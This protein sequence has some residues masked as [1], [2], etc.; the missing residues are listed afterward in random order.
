MG[1]KKRKSLWEEEQKQKRDKPLQSGLRHPGISIPPHCL[2]SH[3]EGI[4]ALPIQLKVSRRSISIR[5]QNVAFMSVLSPS[6]VPGSSRPVAFY[7]ERK[8]AIALSQA[9]LITQEPPTSCHKYVLLFMSAL[10]V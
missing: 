2:P 6:P 1:K 7:V 9:E 8:L 10:A 3:P 5:R 4:L